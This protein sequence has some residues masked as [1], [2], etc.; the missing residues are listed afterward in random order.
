MY[1]IN[2]NNYFKFNGMSEMSE[3]DAIKKLLNLIFLEVLRTRCI[4][5]QQL[6]SQRKDNVYYLD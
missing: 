5:S 3:E 6:A 1:Q 4:K 2:K